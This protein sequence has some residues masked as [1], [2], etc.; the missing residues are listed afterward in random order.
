MTNRAQIRWGILGAADIARKNWKAIRNSGNGIVTMV[1][2]RNLE[3]AQQF[4]QACQSQTAMPELPRATDSYETLINSPD[5]DA[6]YLPI[7]TGLRKEWVIRAAEA[8]KH[9]LCEKPCASN[10]AD[11]EAMVAACAKNKVQFMDGVMF[12]HSARLAGIGRTLAG[13]QAIGELRRITSAFSFCGDK[14]FFEN[15]IR[16]H[17]GLEPHGCL[18]DLGWY[19]IRFSLWAMGEALP[20]EVTGT[21]LDARRRPGSP[22]DVPVAMTV[23]M[24]FNG[25]VTAGFYCSFNAGDQQWVHLSGTTGGLH[26]NDFVL[27]FF[28]HELS[29]E[30]QKAGLIKEEIGRAHV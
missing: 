5:V 28:G 11:L 26:L 29:Y 15:N 30:T 9:V 1:A 13:G 18:G 20:I 17:S 27:P 10:L 25:G 7:P 24:K 23:E 2:S 22:G 6:V 21:M 16:M 19:C 8:G 4:I 14:S 3:Q 12:M